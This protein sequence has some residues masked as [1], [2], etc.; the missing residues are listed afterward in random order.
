MIWETK[1]RIEGHEK[2]YRG[3][4]HGSERETGEKTDLGK[5]NNILMR[6]CAV[7]VMDKHFL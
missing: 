7:I 3:N 2:Y 1:E 6:I 5:R 4:Y